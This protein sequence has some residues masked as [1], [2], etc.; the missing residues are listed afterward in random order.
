MP[1]KLDVSLWDILDV[2]SEIL[3]YTA[4][5]TLKDYLSD[6]QLRRSVERCFIIVGEALVRIRMEFPEEHANLLA[7]AK[8]IN[9]RNHLVHRYN[10]VNDEE[11]WAIVE[12]SLPLL[13]K[14][15]RKSL[16]TKKV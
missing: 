14:E 4:G 7:A 11:V 5:K 1:R 2:G 9:F 13:L 10:V 15:V 3:E 12:L 16:E 6:R 8:A